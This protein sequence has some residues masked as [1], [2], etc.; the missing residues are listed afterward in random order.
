M[1]VGLSAASCCGHSSHEMRRQARPSMRPPP[2]SVERKSMAPPLSDLTT[3]CVAPWAS[4]STV[5]MKRRR[6][7][8]VSPDSALVAL[9]W[10]G[11]LRHLADA[12]V[13]DG[14]QGAERRGVEGPV[15]LVEPQLEIAVRLRLGQLRLVKDAV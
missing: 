14:R 7:R 4:R 10:V 11:A 8:G 2:P 3:M 15:V 13:G 12:L 5:G 1:A 9:R 6:E